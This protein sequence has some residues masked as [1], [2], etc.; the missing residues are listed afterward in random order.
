MT[1][2]NDQQF[3]IEHD[4][5]GEVRVPIDA[6]WRAQ[7]QRAVEN[8]PISGRPLERTQIRAMGLLKAAC[9]QVNKDLGL[10]DA[11]KADAIIAA[12][13][14]I[15]EGKHDDQFPIDVFQTGSGTSSNM[16]ANEV[17]ASIAKAAGV[18]VHPNDH[19]NMSQSSND[20][21]PT[22]T[23]VAATEAAVTDLVPALE[24]LHAA[25]A[26]KATEWK[27]VVKS[28]RT[29]LM[30]AVPVT[31]G[32]EFGGYAR[33]IEAGIERVN[34][35]LPRL[36][37][38]PIGGTAVGTGLNAPDGF[39]PKVV[40]ELVKSTGVDALTPAKNSFEAQAARDGLVEASG[41]LRT[42][43]VSLTKIANDIRW[44]GSGPLTGLGEIALPDLQ[45][46]SSIM[47]GK[48]NPVLPEATTQVA[49][50]VIGNDAAIAWGGAAGA[51]EL[52]V[53]IPVMARNLLESF[54]LLANVSRLLADKCVSGLVAHEEHLKTLAESSPSIVTPLNSAI[55]YEEAA[56]VAKQALKEKKTIRQ[57]VIE[58]GLVPDKLS[59]E[60]LDKRLDVLAMAKVKD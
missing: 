32:Q 57:V 13:N 33:Q 41:A 39:G 49:A 23:H 56:A 48:V 18:D 5:M 12:A 24:H 30:D 46:G 15:A 14:E 54:T 51:F 4:T 7:T 19:V 35:T 55:G 45:P 20:T 53:Y 25:L 28:G 16:N 9:A 11:D 42:I 1:E 34:A 22:A 17:I 44:M 2:S 26:T 58:R 29:H 52:N 47:P 59:E 40:A 27:T 6:L 38:L 43:A 21:F 3:R 31:L 60:E 36:G 10:L 37:E 50:Q 8:F